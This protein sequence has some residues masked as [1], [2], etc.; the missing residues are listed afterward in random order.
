MSVRQP[1]YK[2]GSIDLHVA[3]L[4]DPNFNPDA[5]VRSLNP[6]NRPV[7]MVAHGFNDQGDYQRYTDFINQRYGHLNPPPIVVG[8]KWD[9]NGFDTNK[10]IGEA[11]TG[12]FRGIRG[13]KLG[14]ALG[15]VVGGGSA[16]ADDYRTAEGKAENITPQF[17]QLLVSYN[18][19]HPNSA[20]NMVAHSLGN[21]PMMGAISQGDVKVNTYMAVQ[22]AVDQDKLTPGGGFNDLLDT[23]EVGRLGVTY[24]S[25]DIAVQ[26]RDLIGYNTGLGVGGGDERLARP[27]GT[28]EYYNMQEHNEWLSL[29]HYGYN[30]LASQSK[31]VDFWGADGAGLYGSRRDPR[32]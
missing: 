30:D 8:I 28:T 13:G 26:G 31:M 32:L 19:H 29:N 25:R 23:Q 10:A 22:A 21:A 3:N 7:I 9:S 1:D 14:M 20:V 5:F 11:A 16:F 12:T 27:A 24:T 4:R 2:S 15:G 17:T 18:Y 6:G